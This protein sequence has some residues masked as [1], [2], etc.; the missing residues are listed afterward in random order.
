M[1]ISEFIDAEIEKSE[2]PAEE[3]NAIAEKVKAEFNTDCVLEY[4]GGFDSPG[5]DINCYAFAYVE[6]GE[7][8]IHGYN[9]EC[10]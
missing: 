2:D 6:G 5:Y 10:Y 9:H 1:K 7:L 8:K 3:L 4:I